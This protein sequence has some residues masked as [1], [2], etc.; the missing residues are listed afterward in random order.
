MEVSFAEKPLCGTIAQVTHD[1]LGLNSGYV[2]SYT[3]NYNCRMCLLQGCG[4]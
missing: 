2:K 1:S 3:E 4:N